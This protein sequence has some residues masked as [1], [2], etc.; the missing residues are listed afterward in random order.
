MFVDVLICMVVS[1]SHLS[2]ILEF[3]YICLY[4][5]TRTNMYIYI[6]IYVYK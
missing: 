6:Y 2:I 1:L 5:Y 4:T 3:A